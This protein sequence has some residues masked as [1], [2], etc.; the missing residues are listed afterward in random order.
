MAPKC[1]VRVI[2]ICP[3]YGRVYRLNRF[4][5]GM[6]SEQCQYEATS[7]QAEC[8]VFQEVK[9]AVEELVEEVTG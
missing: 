2:G 1:P 4:A 9:E 5:P 8:E 6:R 3:L 7:S